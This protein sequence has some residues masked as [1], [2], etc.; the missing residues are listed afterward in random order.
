MARI[1]NLLAVGGDKVFTNSY[2]YYVSEL[3]DHVKSLEPLGETSPK[4]IYTTKLEMPLCWPKPGPDD[5]I[6]WKQTF[7]PTHYDGR[8]PM[9]G[10]N[11]LHAAAL[12]GLTCIAMFLPESDLFDVGV[13]SAE[14]ITPLE[15]A[16]MGRNRETQ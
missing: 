12:H 10:C 2:L 6:D 15:F 14:G 1:Y 9:K 3:E 5:N 4:V 11:L 7:E 13:T 8:P 16:S